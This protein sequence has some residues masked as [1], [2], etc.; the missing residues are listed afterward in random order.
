MASSHLPRST[1][2]SQTNLANPPTNCNVYIPTLVAFDELWVSPLSET[3]DTVS[4]VV[5]NKYVER[6]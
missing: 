2:D 5:H 3:G 4:I 1:D 6:K